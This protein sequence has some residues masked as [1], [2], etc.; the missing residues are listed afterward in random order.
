MCLSQ[1]SL[2]QT[3]DVRINDRDFNQ[4]R[5]DISVLLS[6]L[7]SAAVSP[8]FPFA[9]SS[10]FLSHPLLELEKIL[11]LR[12]LQT[13]TLHLQTGDE[14]HGAFHP[15]IHHTLWAKTKLIDDLSLWKVLLVYSQKVKVK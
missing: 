1:K 7:F 8:L 3:S 14:S 2:Q 15:T 13:N 12:T 9:A 4:C 11:L 6:V 5:S 10:N